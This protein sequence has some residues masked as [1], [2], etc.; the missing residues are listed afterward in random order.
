M[1]GGSKKKKLAYVL[2]SRVTYSVLYV[3]STPYS[4]IHQYSAPLSEAV[5][6]EFQGL[7]SGGLSVPSGTLHMFIRIID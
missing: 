5:V 1:D 7:G 3:L 2:C 6:V 4:K